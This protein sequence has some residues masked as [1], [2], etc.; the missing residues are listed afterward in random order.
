[1]KRNLTLA[2]R[3]LWRHRS[4]SLATIATLGVGLGATLA[5]FSVIEAVLLRRLPYPEPERVV[6]LNHHDTNTGIIKD[7]VALGDVV[8][9]ASRARSIDAIGTYGQGPAVIQHN[10]EQLQ[11]NALLATSST[12][13]ILGLKAA[14]GRVITSDDSKPG[15]AQVVMLGH[16]F[17]QDHFASDSSVI[18]RSIRLGQ[19]ELFVVGVVATGWRFPPNATTDLVVS[20]P[21]PT[22]V[23]P[24][25]RRAWTLAIARLKSGVHLDAARSEIASISRALESEYPA[26]NRA[27]TY[28]VL[29]LR[30]ALVGNTKQA[31][32][33]LFAAVAAVMLIALANVCNLVLVRALNRQREAAVRMALGAGRARIAVQVATEMGVIGVVSAALGVVV[34]H[35]GALSLVHLVPESARVPGLE[36]IRVSPTIVVVALGI[37]VIATVLFGAIAATQHRVESL[38]GTLAAGV[39]SSLGPVARRAVSGI[40]CA[41]LAFAVLLLFGAGLVLKSFATLLAVQP[42]FEPDRVA[43]VSLTLPNELYAT[44]DARRSLYDR[45]FA[46]V[47]AKPGIEDVGVAAITPLTGNNWTHPL[48]RPEAPPAPGER[49]P[50]VGWQIASEGYF[51]ALRIPL[52]AGRLFN[53]MDRPDTRPVV[54]V[55]DALERRYFADGGAV[56]KH[57]RLGNGN[58]AEIVGVVGSIRRAA[59]TDEARLDMYLPAE[60]LAPGGLTLFVRTT[61]E[62]DQA[63]PAIREAVA[64]V[65]PRIL[66]GDS[67]P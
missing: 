52:K 56:G 28:R 13:E 54:I 8:D 51:K 25:A 43:R 11:A 29:S 67:A 15:A 55:S 65:E 6:I 66:T 24:D 53:A 23:Q 3:S 4:F 12:L 36:A 39:R 38:A 33:L 22:Q 21:F 46:A 34:A 44:P 45:I 31:L 37:T 59:L 27:S 60:R 64:S 50:E 2:V 10:G 42:G 48:V 32:F 62:T 49:A 63:M 57:V 18:N 17:W 16:R 47:A 9:F 5:V 30:D 61:G 40:V 1:M 20:Q 41:E 26:T 14:L 58:E 7:F 35:W 19:E